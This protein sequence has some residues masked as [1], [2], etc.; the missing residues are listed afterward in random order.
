[1]TKQS[2]AA[3]SIAKEVQRIIDYVRDCEVRATRGEVLELQGLDQNVL[4]VCNKIAGLDVPHSK[5]VEPMMA[6]L[7]EELDNLASTLKTQQDHIIASS[8]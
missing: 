6:T 3:S 5:V 4:I 2:D 8:G 7:I 1:M